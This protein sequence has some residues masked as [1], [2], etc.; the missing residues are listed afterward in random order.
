[1]T[2]DQWAIAFCRELLSS[3]AAVAIVGLVL[4]AISGVWPP[5]VAV[6]SG[7]M[8]PVM[9][10]GDLV[11]IMDEDRLPP[12]AAKGDRGVVP[13]KQGQ[14]IDYRSF[15]DYGDVIVYDPPDRRGPP[16]I[17]RSRFWVTEG[18]NWY[19]RA[20][21][22][23]VGTA[24]NCEELRNCPAPNP[25][26]ITKGDANPTYDQSQGLAPPVRPVWITG[27]GEVRVQGLGLVRLCWRDWAAC[28]A[29]AE[30]GSMSGGRSIQ[31]GL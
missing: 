20:N 6:E 21:E 30:T 29:R 3:A 26:F 7:S 1:L 27:T 25:G 17:H 12:K 18:E 2:T 22:T 23:L 11:F 10:R 8:E 9:E 19:D 16:I 13:Y 5:M 14:A 28:L 4:F 15:N 31:A 24:D